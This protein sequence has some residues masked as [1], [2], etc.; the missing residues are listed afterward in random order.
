MIIERA[1][2]GVVV[3][4]AIA[5]TAR[6]AGSL[7]TSGALAA[8]AVG[9]AAV[10]TGWS[11]GA[12]LVIY[13]VTASLL[14][15]LGATEKARRTGAVVEKGGARDAVQVAANGGVFALCALASLAIDREPAVVL[16]TAALGAL[17]AASADTWATEVGTLVGG[18]PRSLL[19]WRRVPIGTSGAVSMAGTLAMLAGALFIATIAHLL[20]LSPAIARVAAAGALGAVADS[21][22]GAT[23][24]ERRWCGACALATERR[25]HDCGTATRLTGGIAGM[26]ND[27]VNFV[28]TVIGAA[29]AAALVIV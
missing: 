8:T 28:A 20:S 23:I 29:V 21:L 11:W 18:P 16:A 6:R 12:V 15:R 25:V 9:A 10:A 2:A 3:A 24:Q 14:S 19:T 1:A 26:D 13:F 22:L 4:A 27:A 7:S 17:A 5:F